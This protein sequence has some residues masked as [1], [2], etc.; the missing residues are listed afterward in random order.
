MTVGGESVRSA[1]DRSAVNRGSC[2]QSMQ[3]NGSSGLSS[4]LPQMDSY[5]SSGPTYSPLSEL[6]RAIILR[7][8]ED[9]NGAP[10]LREEAIDYMMN[11]DEEYIFSFISICQHLG[12]DPEKTRMNIMYS[13][14]RIATRRRAS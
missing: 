3:R 1:V 2:E 11:S 5:N 4:R 9:Y 10:N 12:L 14:R 13:N 6:M 8:V 7:V